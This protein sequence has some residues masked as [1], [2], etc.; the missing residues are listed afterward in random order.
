MEKTEKIESLKALLRPVIENQGAF[1][2]DISLRG[3]PRR[4]LMEVYCET[5]NGIS[6]EKCSEI[7]REI[8]PLIDSSKVV[9]DNFRLE[10]S[11][12]G[13]GVPLKD[14][15][16]FKRNIGKLMSV[17]YRDGLEMKQVEGDVVDV[18]EEKVVIGTPKSPIE[19]EFDSIDEAIVKIR[20]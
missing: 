4:P 9:G 5:E 7:S 3:D 1:L 19:I 18:K 2:V 10:V 14:R 8:L 12:P 16:Q 20:W 6:I 13:V 15:R 11:S 17:K